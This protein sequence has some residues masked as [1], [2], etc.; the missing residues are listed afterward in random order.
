MNHPLR[1][2]VPSGADPSP[3]LR[4]D[5]GDV[6]I[7]S[8]YGPDGNRM[9]PALVAALTRALAVAQADPGI[10]AVVLASARRD[11]CAG[12][13]ADLPPPGPDAVTLPPV[14][15]ALADLCAAIE[16]APKPVVAALSGRVAAGGL[17][18]ALA[19]AAR[20][21]TPGSLFRV[22]EARLGRLPVGCAAVRLAQ[23]IGAAPALALARGT[24]LAANEAL[25]LGLVDALDLRPLAL[26]TTRAR[27]L[28]A[29]PR[30]PRPPAPDT[31]SAG[32]RALVQ[33]RA[34]LPRPL[35]AHRMAE[36]ALIDVIEAA[37]LLPSEQ[38]QAFDLVRA[39]DTALTP[40]ARALAH[41]ARAAR[42]AQDPTP[43]P[44]PGPVLLAMEPDTA[45]RWAP[46]LLHEGV[47][48]RL[49]A[50]DRD[51]LSAGLAAIRAAQRARV[52]R[53][54]LTQ[55]EAEADSARLSG[56]RVPELP[57]AVA[58][59]DAAHLDWL[60]GLLPSEVPLAGWD[61]PPGAP[62]G[63][64]PSA[65]RV[66]ALVPAPTRP[67]RLCEVI[68][69]PDT[70]AEVLARVA[71]LALALRLTPLIAR[72]G[73]LLAPLVLAAAQAAARLRA[74]GVGAA[75]LAQVPILP[76]GLAQGDSAPVT[77]PLPLPAERLVLLA[78]VNAGLRLLAQARAARPSD[79]DLAL[80]MGAGWPDWR[81]GPMAEGDAL[82]PLVLRHDLRLA[83]P[84]DPALWTPEP[85]L[86]E[87]IRRGWRFEDLNT[88]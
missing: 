60:E 4:R 55:A 73:P 79:L 33:A 82:G 63:L 88:G 65:R 84:L 2:E 49:L 59:S 87:L 24:P 7:L 20:V 67:L 14:V 66:V 44:L 54:H 78:V 23:R 50:R 75:D 47:Q 42:R 12:A 41:V 1:S 31:G 19:C 30:P 51:A 72:G 15:T 27:A 43:P 34:D 56:H 71:A 68:A 18:L 10:V 62:Q 11:F 35:P 80:V 45:A 39:Q 86:D 21:A 37:L 9:G 85:I 46:V 58:L 64:R 57:V 5:D 74:A 17:A 29:A 22:P 40:A 28:A 70:Q 25:R 6:A 3:V 26:A 38:A 81:G 69:A 76:P 13:F 48:V 32:M 52:R 36:A 8:L 61:L 83:A 16:G 53:G 77:E